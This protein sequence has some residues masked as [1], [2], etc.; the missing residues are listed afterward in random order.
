L[1]GETVR[2]WTEKASWT[3]YN[4]GSRAGWTCSDTI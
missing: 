3:F 4:R 2:N 1:I